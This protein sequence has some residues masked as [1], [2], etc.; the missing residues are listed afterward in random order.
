VPIGKE[1][2]IFYAVCLGIGC[3]KLWKPFQ[4]SF[5]LM[6]IIAGTILAMTGLGALIGIPMILLG[7]IDLFAN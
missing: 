2:L 5:G 7:G 1:W 3:L 4:K 6:L